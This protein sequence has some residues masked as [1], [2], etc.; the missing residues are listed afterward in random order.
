MF[1]GCLSYFPMKLMTMILKKTLLIA[2]TC[3]L[4]SL[5]FIEVPHIIPFRLILTLWP[6]GHIAVFA[7]L[8]L[9]SLTYLPFL[10]HAKWQQQLLWLTLGCAVVGISIELIQPLF[11]RTAELE[12]VFLNYLGTL[13]TFIIMGNFTNHQMVKLSLKSLYGVLLIYLITPTF[14]TAYDEYRLLNDFPSIATYY[15]ETSL[16][17]WKANGSLAILN[18]EDLNNAQNNMLQATFTTRSASRVVMRFFNENWQIGD[19]KKLQFRFFNPNVEQVPLTII[20]T[21]KHYDKSHSNKKYRFEEK[22]KLDVG[23]STHTIL[24]D[25]IKQQPSAQNLDLTKMAGIDFYMYK[26]TKPIT[27]LID[28]IKLIH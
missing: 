11:S 9:L 24:L 15:N 12:D 19:Y 3:L 14:L 5:L 13:A 25:D 16:S 10:K 2:L 8:S 18:K 26:L 23:W 4:I 28:E 1:N 6:L 21:D 7:L 22:I 17:R 20:M 27:L